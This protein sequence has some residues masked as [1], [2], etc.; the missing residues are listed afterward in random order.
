MK[1]F[2]SFLS[3]EKKK[4]REKQCLNAGKEEGSSDSNQSKDTLLI[5]SSVPFTRFK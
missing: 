2:C 4:E 5:A 1:P 3:D